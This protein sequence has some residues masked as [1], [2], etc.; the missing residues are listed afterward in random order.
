[1]ACFVDD[2]LWGGNTEFETI[3]NKLKQLFRISTELKQTFEYICIKLEQ[4]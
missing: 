3:I 2:V 4:I 1:M